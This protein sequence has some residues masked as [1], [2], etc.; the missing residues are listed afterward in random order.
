MSLI[1]KMKALKIKKR[2]SGPLKADQE[3]NP[4]GLK[5]TQKKGGLLFSLRSRNGKTRGEIHEA[6]YQ[7]VPEKGMVSF[8]VNPA[9]EEAREG[10]DA[11]GHELTAAHQRLLESFRTRKNAE[12][13]ESWRGSE[14]SNFSD[15]FEASLEE[16]FVLTRRLLMQIVGPLNDRFIQN[17]LLL[18]RALGQVYERLSLPIPFNL[19]KKGYIRFILDNRDRLLP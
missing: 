8:L 10:T 12:W 13:K 18:E 5:N 9:K 6:P 1:P 19:W 7:A 3:L 11:S 2:N 16:I 14:I 4:R 17:D 15:G